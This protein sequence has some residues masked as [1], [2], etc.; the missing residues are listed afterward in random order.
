MFADTIPN[1]QETP[2]SVDKRK[3]IMLVDDDE[4]HLEILRFGL[5]YQGFDV[6]S[7]TSGEGLLEKIQQQ[8]PDAV[9]LD[10]Y[11]PDANGLDICHILMDNAA[12]AMIPVIVLSGSIETSI[13]RQ[14][15]SAG[16]RYFLSNPFD[17]NTILVMLR[18]AI[19]EAQN[20]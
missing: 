15:R 14:A 12:T 20:L 5:E 8:K 11:L 13:V 4:T 1:P 3:T 2:E 18:Q 9:I 10:V 16:C 7:L 19:D 17:P 6:I